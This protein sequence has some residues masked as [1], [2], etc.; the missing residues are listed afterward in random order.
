MTITRIG[1]NEKYAANWASAFGKKK[2]SKATA[3]AK[4][5]KS[6]KP[7]KKNAPAKKPMAK[8]K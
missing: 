8:K 1:S 7:G 4:A 2:T 5:P 3:S 6:K